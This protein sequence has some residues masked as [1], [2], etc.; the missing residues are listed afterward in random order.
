M[1]YE[2]SQYLFSVSINKT[3][4]QSGELFRKG[5]EEKHRYLEVSKTM[6]KWLH[7][8]VDKEEDPEVAGCA[9]LG[10]SATVWCRIDDTKQKPLAVYSLCVCLLYMF[11]S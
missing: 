9:L 6:R 2:N 7:V 5:C 1:H 4:I 8:V 10:Y 3:L 11:K